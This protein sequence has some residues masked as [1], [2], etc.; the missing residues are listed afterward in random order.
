[1]NGILSE[2]IN[3][4][5]LRIKNKGQ[6]VVEF[7]LLCA[8]CAAIGIFARDVD[9]SGAFEES[10]DK[11]KPVLYAAEIGQRNRDNYMKFYRQWRYL[12]ADTVNDVDNPKRIEADQKALVKIAETYLGKTEN[13]VMNL[14]DYYSNS[15]K[16][17][18]A[19]EFIK[20]LKCSTASG[21]GFS[22][23]VL[24]P[25][26]YKNN[27]L[28]KNGDSADDR[29]K[30]WVHYERNNNQNTALYLTNNE[31]RVY[32]KYD[33]DNP[34]YLYNKQRNTVC[35]DRLFFSDDMLN[36]TAAKVTVR[37]HYTDGK[38]DFVDI[39]LRTGNGDAWVSNN[40]K[41][42]EGLC[43]HVT[44]AGHAA[45]TNTGSAGS[46]DIINKPTNYYKNDSEH[47]YVVN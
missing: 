16:A 22:T 12:T 28:D 36:N 5:K 6:G 31:A 29:T 42:A 37:L 1:M 15:D 17:N 7:A 13:Q 41:F 14:M 45:I 26:S 38:V 21:T 8:F 18:V 44:E 43:L 11:S 35:T 46:N 3:R 25:M 30:G 47:T 27:S 40:N 19:P 33:A 39:A 24:V 2:L 34:N 4:L 10:L 9:F 20:D 23:G 32:D